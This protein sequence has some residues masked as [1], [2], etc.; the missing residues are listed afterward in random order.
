[1]NGSAQPAADVAIVGAGIVGLACALRLQMDGRK[2]VLVDPNEPAS[3]CSHGNSGYLA[4]GHVFP[5]AALV[6][7]SRLPKALFDPLGPLVLRAGALPAMIPWALRAAATLRPAALAKAMDA[8]AALNRAAIGSFVPYLDAAHARDLFD[9]QGALTIFQTPAAL[10][11]ACTRIPAIRERGLNVERLSG[12]QV[13]A[14]EAALSPD[15]AG[16]LFYPDSGRCL[17]P[18]GLGERFANALAANGAVFHRNAVSRLLPKDG[19][20]WTIETGGG[21]MLT[22]RQVVVSAGARTHRLLNPLGYRVPL[23][24]ERGYHLMLPPQSRVSLTRPVS[25]GEQFFTMTPMEEGF[26]LAGTAEYADVD[27]PMDPRRADLLLGL[28][29]RYLPALEGEGATRWMGA[30]PSLPDG[31][32]VIGRAHRHGDLYC[33]FGHQHLG[34]T[35]AAISADVLG[36]LMAGRAP[37]ID[38]QPY[39]L[40]RFEQ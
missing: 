19:G 37:A 25:A 11:R 13:H 8:I 4:E 27:A 26:R 39:A 6:P 34:L 33:C 15:L 22:A 18:R 29:R 9:R 20:G 32:P 12:A 16:A 5:P 31:L 38:T 21:P 3:G 14:L 35:Q 24:A 10:E 40:N 28:A 7:L 23:A 30:R 2:V 36:A 1:V 17:N